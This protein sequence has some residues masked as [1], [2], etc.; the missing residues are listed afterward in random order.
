[1]I[2]FRKKPRQP[3]STDHILRPERVQVARLPT[4]LEPL[5][6]MG[7]ELGIDLWVKR[8]DLTGAGLSGNKIRKLDYL[9]AQALQ[10]NADTLITCGGTQSNHAR[11][12]A[13]AGARLGLKSILILRGTPPQR[14]EGN[15]LLDRMV[16]ADIRWVSPEQYKER[17]RLFHEIADEVRISGGRPYCIPEGGSNALGAWGYLDAM[18]EIRTQSQESGLSFDV[19]VTA[20]GSGGT[21]AGLAVG[22]AQHPTDTPFPIG[23]N[24]CD[25]AAY[26]HGRI[27]EIWQSMTETYGVTP[28]RRDAYEIQDGFVG[29]GYAKSQQQELD[30][31]QDVA[32]STGLLLD[33]VYT[34]KAFFALTQLLTTDSSLLGKRILFLHTGG[35]FGLFAKA[36]S[37]ENVLAAD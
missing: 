10:E 12:T 34:G 2:P 25:D 6:S 14:L 17:D 24:V 11:A 7:D 15:Q 32:R 21:L 19:L 27:K 29:L 20:V 4:P 36:G 31:L 30:L 1:M 18:E 8:D 26:F 33:P 22:H 35:L 16:N 13:L 28:Y 23:V 5:K 37:P 3:M 9:L